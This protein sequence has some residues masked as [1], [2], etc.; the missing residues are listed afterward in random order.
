MDY[1]PAPIETSGVTLSPELMQL[2]ERLAENAHDV[3][4]RQRLS[5]GWVYGPKRDDAQKHHPCLIPY[6]AL[7]ESEKEY[8]RNAALHTLKA[9]VALGF[10]IQKP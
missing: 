2:R 4:A 6:A 7:P 10:R 5:E 1:K 8:D 3:W 9:I